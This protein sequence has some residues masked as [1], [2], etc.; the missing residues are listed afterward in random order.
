MNKKIIIG[1]FALTLTTLGMVFQEAEDSADYP[2]LISLGNVS[3]SPVPGTTNVEHPGH[4]IIQF[5]EIPYFERMEE[6][7]DLGIDIQRYIGG[8][9]YIARSDR[10]WTAA[11]L[12]VAGRGHLRAVVKIASDMRLHSSFV[13]SPKLQKAKQTNEVITIDV[14]FHPDVPYGR[15]LQ[16]MRGCKIECN[17]DGYMA[18]NRLI[19]E[20]SWPSIQ[21][22]VNACEWIR[23]SGGQSFMNRME[24]AFCVE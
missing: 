18:S 8:N 21:R 10:S 22:L 14:R 16:V 17:P 3:F 24:R 19:G 1:I 15:A 23:F 11:E 7:A 12:A 4:F 2:Y 13:Y 6:Y 9:A 20:A 5:Y